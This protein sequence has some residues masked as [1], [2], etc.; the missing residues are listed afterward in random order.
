[1]KNTKQNTDKTIK[2]KYT[3]R[4]VGSFSFA[5]ISLA[6]LASKFSDSGTRIPVSTKWAGMKGFTNLKPVS[7]KQVVDPVKAEM[8]ISPTV[9]VA[10]LNSPVS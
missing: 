8:E 4:R 5:N 2:N 7:T 1:M 9:V 10:D 6:D 3:G